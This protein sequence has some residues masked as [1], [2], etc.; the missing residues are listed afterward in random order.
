MSPQDD[1]RYIRELETRCALLERAFLIQEKRVW[2]QDMLKKLE[3]G[4]FMGGAPERE[5]ARARA[6]LEGNLRVARE[7][8]DDLAADLGYEGQSAI[9][10]LD[11]EFVYGARSEELSPGLT[12]QLRRL[13]AREQESGSAHVQAMF[14]DLKTRHDE[15]L[16]EV[17]QQVRRDVELHSIFEAMAVE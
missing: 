11:P 7:V 2:S 15:Y 6:L 4:A 17:Q 3:R 14:R 9:K 13:D 1:A 12:E 5:K 8:L 16:R 10:L